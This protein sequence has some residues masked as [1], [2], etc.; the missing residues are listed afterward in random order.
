MNTNINSLQ[1]FNPKKLN[2]NQSFGSKIEYNPSLKKDE[3]DTYSF[4]TKTDIPKI[5]SNPVSK[6]FKSLLLATQT[7]LG[8]AKMVFNKGEL[9]VQNLIDNVATKGGCTFVGISV[10]N[11]ENS[12]KLFY[13]VID[14]TAKKAHELGA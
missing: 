14:E 7:A 1:N 3:G 8:S 12:D 11:N 9:T 2:Q 4:S 6:W 13:D 5:K 10:M